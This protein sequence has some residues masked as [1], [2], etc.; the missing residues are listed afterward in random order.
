MDESTSPRVD[1]ETRTNAVDG[2]ESTYVHVPSQN[3]L[4]LAGSSRNRAKQEANSFTPKYT[5]PLSSGQTV[6]KEP[7][8]TTGSAYPSGTSK[9]Q[10]VSGR[11]LAANDQTERTYIDK[12]VLYVLADAVVKGTLSELGPSFSEK[13][14]AVAADQSLMKQLATIIL[15]KQQ[16]S[17]GDKTSGTGDKV[18]TSSSL[19]SESLPKNQHS[20]KPERNQGTSSNLQQELLQGSD[21]SDL[22]ELVT[23]KGTKV[24]MNSATG[25]STPPLNDLTTP[26]LAEVRQALLETLSN[27][28]ARGEISLSGADLYSK[29]SDAD[30]VQTITKSLSRG[31]TAES[32]VQSR[33]RKSPRSRSLG[34]ASATTSSNHAGKSK[35]SSGHRLDTRDESPAQTKR[36]KSPPS[37][38][39]KERGGHTPSS[40]VRRSASPPAKKLTTPKKHSTQRTASERPQA[41]G[42]ARTP[43][44]TPL[45]PKAHA[46][47]SGGPTPQQSNKGSSSQKAVQVDDLATGSREALLRHVPEESKLSIGPESQNDSRTSANVDHEEL[48]KMDKQLS[49]EHELRE[50]DKKGKYRGVSPQRR[51]HKNEE[52][53]G[54]F[55]S[56]KDRGTVSPLRVRPI[57]KATT[58]SPGENGG[59]SDDAR[60]AHPI[61]QA[62]APSGDDKGTSD[63][64][65]ARRELATLSP[66]NF[67]KRKT[68]NQ[69]IPVS[70]TSGSRVKDVDSI[71][72]TVPAPRRPAPSPVSTSSVAHVPQTVSIGI[73]PASEGTGLSPR[74]RP[75]GSGPRPRPSIDPSGPRSVPG[76]PGSGSGSPRPNPP[77]AAPRPIPAGPRPQPGPRPSARAA[78]PR[79]TTTHAGETG[80]PSSPPAAQGGFLAELKQKGSSALKK[81]SKSKNASNTTTPSLATSATTVTSSA[82][83][84]SNTAENNS[85]DTEGIV[86]TV[87]GPEGPLEVIMKPDGSFLPRDKPKED[88][89][90]AVTR[91]YNNGDFTTASERDRPHSGNQEQSSPSEDHAKSSSEPSTREK[92]KRKSKPKEAPPSGQL[93]GF[94]YFR[95]SDFESRLA[96]G[97]PHSPDNPRYWVGCVAEIM[98]NGY[99]RLHWHREMSLKSGIYIPTNHFFTERASVLKPIYR[100][101]R[102]K[103]KKAWQIDPVVE[104]E[105]DTSVVTSTVPDTSVDNSKYTETPLESLGNTP[106]QEST[107][108]GQLEPTGSSQEKVGTQQ[109]KKQK[110]Q[111]SPGQF[112]ILNNSM[113][114]P[115]E[116]SVYLPKYWICRVAR[117]NSSAVDGSPAELQLQ[118]FR[119]TELGSKTFQ[120]T[121]SF[122]DEDASL[123]WPLPGGDLVYD[124]KERL[125]VSTFEGPMEIPA[126][127]DSPV[128]NSVNSDYNTSTAPQQQTHATSSHRTHLQP[129]KQ[130]EKQE[131]HSDVD[132]NTASQSSKVASAENTNAT[133]HT[134]RQPDSSASRVDQGVAESSADYELS[135]TTPPNRGD[136]TYPGDVVA[137]EEEPF[138]PRVGHFAFTPNAQFDGRKSE[139]TTN[140]RFF[141]MRIDELIERE[142]RPVDVPGGGAFARLTWF[143][144]T[145]TRGRDFVATRHKFDEAVT[146]LRPLPDIKFKTQAA[147]GSPIYTLEGPYNTSARF[148]PAPSSALASSSRATDTRKGTSRG[149]TSTPYPV[150]TAGG[151]RSDRLAST[152]TSAVAA[153]SKAS[154]TPTNRSNQEPVSGPYRANAPTNQSRVPP[155]SNGPPSQPAPQTL[156]GASNSGFVVEPD[157]EDE[158][159][160]DTEPF[161]RY[162]KALPR[163]IELTKAV[164]PNLNLY[165]L[166]KLAY[167]SNTKTKVRKGSVAV[168]GCST[169]KPSAG[170]WNL[171]PK[172]FQWHVMYD[173]NEKGKPKTA[174]PN[175]LAVQIW[176]AGTESGGSKDPVAA[177]HTFIATGILNLSTKGGV[178]LVT[179][180]YILPEVENYVPGEVSPPQ[181]PFP[182]DDALDEVFDKPYVSQ[183]PVA[184]DVRQEKNGPPVGKAYINA[185]IIDDALPDEES[186][187]GQ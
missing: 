48:E 73:I 5:K 1:G 43:Q 126:E 47:S 89:P 88:S 6:E 21:S 118:W 153:S 147:D 50:S 157:D 68:E 94:M 81:R 74:P 185:W 111:V 71:A 76:T 148:S 66:D 49:T 182:L 145:E 110:V 151:E 100:A 163:K 10:R 17:T 132:R 114:T 99:M 136:S 150:S 28:V 121:P 15:M 159:F 55:R 97:E 32:H 173:P 105:E 143:K 122:F 85:S 9:E 123:V 141:V 179:S 69:D 142:D 169:S 24:T 42:S 177:G 149:S 108:R 63:D 78:G 161:P 125:W 40:R 171:D 30:A 13:M 33:K 51:V 70:S 156:Q 80:Q 84:A 178:S 144:Q 140:P 92:A 134:A 58:P 158:E 152:P 82:A 61:S 127:D 56:T 14:R 139:S 46:K 120:P 54:K 129:S 154:D 4:P 62:P 115:E 8:H 116:H 25:E 138:E 57:S 86:I 64:A 165:I 167:A 155:S 87:T 98:M 31:G 44:R 7:S 67:P 135:S 96:S 170:T 35:L 72:A 186:I 18:Q 109:T 176:D 39:L 103:E 2:D 162:I 37:R 113:F 183:E 11:A 53:H 75:P 65:R 174:T 60:T 104:D 137:I 16:G 172:L 20:G 107:S 106:K 12:S 91:A 128:I 180:P 77:R 23:S 90:A 45:K 3:T 22:L 166:L 160:E 175:A 29:Q 112:V 27:K 38:S 101:V 26:E 36:G 187:E 34:K 59:T 83:S 130:V 95:N 19:E 52:Y 41:A 164:S 133:E 168:S 93:G 102:L 146:V 181:G 117:I 124:S 131:T 79:P 119:E 184:V